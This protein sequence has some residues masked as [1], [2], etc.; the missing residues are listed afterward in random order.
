MNFKCMKQNLIK[1]QEE[2]DKATILVQNFNS[3]LSIIE[4]TIRKRKYR[5]FEKCYQLIDIYR[6]LEPN[7]AEYTLFWRAHFPREDTFCVIQQVSMN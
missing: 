7:I 5:I 1:F 2:V 3:L 6:T 4:K